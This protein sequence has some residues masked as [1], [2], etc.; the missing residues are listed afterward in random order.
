M[1]E[2]IKEFRG[3]F[4]EIYTY[5]LCLFLPSRKPSAK[6]L[7]FSFG[8]T[9]SDLLMSLLRSHPKFHCDGELLWK[10]VFFPEKFIK[11][12]EVLCKRQVYGFKML[13]THF[14]IQG[15]A[16]PTEF[17]QELNLLG[18]KVINLRRR[19]IIRQSISH[20]YALHRKKF[21]H[22]ESQG[23]QMHKKIFIPIE[24]FQRELEL[25]S[26]CNLME[27]QILSNIPNMQLYY[28]D[29]LFDEGMHQ[30]TINR[31]CDYLGVSHATVH[32]EFLKTTPLD[33]SIIID[34]Y[35]DLLAYKNPTKFPNSTI[36]LNK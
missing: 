9:G 18:Y 30:F 3:Y 28:E 27:S 13:S 23:V 6:F 32:T 31:I 25:I 35:E 1:F 14:A 20:I 4:Q 26:S 17:I 34:N 12:K 16:D 15:I 19:D 2:Q 24:Q 22:K 21:H 29:D 10:K 8:R 5:G 7:I 33:L 11:S 36:K